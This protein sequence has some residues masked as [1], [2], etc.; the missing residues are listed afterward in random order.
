MD[1]EGVW[2]VVDEVVWML[3]GEVVWVLGGEVVWVLDGEVVWMLDGA[4][5][6]VWAGGV[7]VV[8]VTTA[9]EDA[10]LT[11]VCGVVVLRGVEVEWHEKDMELMPMLHDDLGLSG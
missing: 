10:V 7:P 1:D 11:S 4:L 9:G 3:G 5:G 6:V 2:T 8:E